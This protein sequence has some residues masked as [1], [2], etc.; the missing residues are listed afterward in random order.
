MCNTHH[1]NGVAKTD[2]NHD[3]HHEQWSRRSFIQALGLAGSGTIMLGGSNLAAASPSPLALALSQAEND[4]VLVIVRLKGG[5]DGLNTIIPLAQYGVYSDNRRDLRITSGNYFNLSDEFA[6]PNFMSDFQAMWGD[7][8]MKVVHGVGYPDQ[9]LSHFRSSDIWATGEEAEE[10]PTGWLGRYFEELYPDYLI[11]SPDRPAA[12]QIGSIGNPIFEGAENNYAF[13]VANPNQLESIANSGSVYDM[14]NLPDCKY[15]SQLGFMRGVTN[16]TYKYANV[17]NEAY[18][19]TTNEADYQDNYFADQMAIVARLIKGNLGTKVFMVSIGG[20]DTHANQVNEHQILMN[21][22]S[23]AI[24][25]FFQDLAAAGYE[26]KVLAMTISEFGRRVEQNGSMGTDHGSCAPMMLFG[27]AL[28]GNGFIGEHPSLTDLDNNGNMR[29][30]VDFREIYA[31]ML[32]DWLCLDAQF[33]DTALLGKPFDSLEGAN[34]SC[35]GSLGTEDLL[36]GNSFE[37]FASYDNNSVAVNFVLPV[38]AR[39]VVRLYNIIGQDIGVLMDE[40]KSQGT[41]SVDV[42]TAVKRRLSRGQYIYRIS[43]GGRNYSKSILVS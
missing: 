16:T 2:K 10:I 19:S 7:G 32:K 4:R 21:R 23:S 3:K 30:S 27:P 38:N 26:D 9:N 41:H 34:I 31:T 29:F 35:P 17:I 33:V 40:F 39:V 14:E 28:N 13:T 24:S 8:K 20:F 42:K 11:S 12:I 43:T 5:N 22:V 15:G 18:T 36:S 1:I 25:N 6:M 37:H